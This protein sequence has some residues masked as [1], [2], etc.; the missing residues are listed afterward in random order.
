MT[1]SVLAVNAMI[2]GVP[3]EFVSDDQWLP[4]GVVSF[5]MFVTCIFMFSSR[6]TPMRKRLIKR[7]TNNAEIE[8][9][10]KVRLQAEEKSAFPNF[11]PKQLA[12]P[13]YP[14][15]HADVGRTTLLALP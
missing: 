7:K 5:P 10:A 8:A 1:T 15:Q 2:Y 13:A 11:D 12:L 4:S 3:R 6:P 14:T 9:I